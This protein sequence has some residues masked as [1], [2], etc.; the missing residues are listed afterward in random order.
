M[1]YKKL[2]APFLFTGHAMLDDNWVLIANENGT[3]E[4]IVPKQEAGE[5][6]LYFDGIITPGFINCHCHI[7]LSHMKGLIPEHT[8]LVPFIFSILQNRFADEEQIEAAIYKA[9]HA[10][11]ANGIVAV[12]DICNTI[13]SLAAKQN[14]NLYYHNFIEV[15][16]FHPS[17]ANNRWQQIQ[18]VYEQFLHSFPAQTSL[19]PHAPYSTSLQ[20]LTLINTHNKH[21]LSSIHMQESADEN[22][23]F[24]QAEGSFTR[25]YKQLQINLSDFH[26]PQHKNSLPYFI[27]HYQQP[28]KTILVHNTFTNTSDIH[29]LQNSYATKQYFHCL[30]VNANSYIENAFPPIMQMLQQQCTMV[31]GTDSLASNHQLSVLAE[32]QTIQ[33]YFSN[34][35]TTTLLQWATINGALALGIENSVGSFEKNKKPGIVGINHISNNGSFTNLSTATVLI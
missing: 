35:P 24:Q 34:I 33:Q 20:L 26:L 3:I 6:L 5:E 30:C 25:L 16:G 28:Q 12:G 27:P 7:E 21:T 31:I 8:G 2:N 32:L 14:S 9:I 23:F 1:A 19:V 10:M 22:L 4:N 11:Q 15:S 13:Y 17:V 29:W 18:P